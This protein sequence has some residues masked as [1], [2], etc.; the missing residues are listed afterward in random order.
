[1][2]LANSEQSLAFATFLAPRA[3]AAASVMAV[4]DFAGIRY[5]VQ[6]SI[7]AY[8]ETKSE[9]VCQ[10]DASFKAAIESRARDSKP[11]SGRLPP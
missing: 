4:I 2:R 9:P 10:L 7:F 1:M 8:R 3:S 5:S 11:L 6:I